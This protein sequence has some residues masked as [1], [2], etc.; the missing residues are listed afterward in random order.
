MFTL[1]VSAYQK[2]R[3]VD[4]TLTVYAT[5][6]CQ[7][8]TLTEI[9]PKLEHTK[10]IS[11]Q[12]A[13]GNAEASNAGQ[14]TAGGSTRFS[15]YMNNPHWRLVVRQ[16]S[17]VRIRL[18]TYKEVA[19]NL[20][21][22]KG[23]KRITLINPELEI[24]NSGDY[25]QGFCYVQIDRLPEGTYMVVPST[26]YPKQEAPIKVTNLASSLVKGLTLRFDC[27]CSAKALRSSRLN[28]SH[29][30]GMGLSGMCCAANGALRKGQML[31]V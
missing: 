26:Y 15:T 11:Y 7:A 18:M 9:V 24:A 2:K 5:L 3:Q 16:T 13:N 28:G 27:R 31:G 20:R 14:G 22:F 19:C 8:P 29:R 10:N 1:V 12:W 6:H 4:Y 23:F 21:V 17:K 30:R 25:R